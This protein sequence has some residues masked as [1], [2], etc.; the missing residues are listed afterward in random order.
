MK[1]IHCQEYSSVI[2]PPNVGTTTGAR[3]AATPKR[4]CAAPCFSVGKASS[5]RRNY[6]LISIA[7]FTIS[8]VL[9]GL[10]TSLGQLR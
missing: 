4:V 6:F 9:C 3:S 1:K 10:A 8:S 5:G 7:I 2:Q